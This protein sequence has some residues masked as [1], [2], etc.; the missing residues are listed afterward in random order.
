MGKMIISKNVG[1]GVSL[2]WVPSTSDAPKLILELAA[3][4]KSNKKVAP[5]SVLHQWGS[6]EVKEMPDDC[7]AHP[8]HFKSNQALVALHSPDGFV[9]KTLK[10]A[11]KE[12]NATHL[13]KHNKF[14]Q[15]GL[16]PA[17]IVATKKAGFFPGDSC[18]EEFLAIR[19]AVAGSKNS[20]A[21]LVWTLKFE[22]SAG[23]LVPDGLALIN[24]KQ[25]IVKTD[26]GS[27][28]LCEPP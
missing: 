10:E 21:Q 9:V 7:S 4:A 19:D 18:R 2:S 23:R 13:Y 22:S 6:G 25:V 8:F 11:V 17:N 14:A 1:N 26:V 27:D 28:L 24:T 12:T 15:K 16:A 5:R 3:D 20:L